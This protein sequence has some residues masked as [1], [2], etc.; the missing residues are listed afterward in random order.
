MRIIVSEKAKKRKK[1][2]VKLRHYWGIVYPS[3]YADD[4][5]DDCDGDGDGDGGSGE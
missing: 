5:T 2:K 1:D 3:G 4:M